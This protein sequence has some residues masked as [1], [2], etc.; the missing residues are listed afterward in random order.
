VHPAC[1]CEGFEGPGN[2]EIACDFQQRRVVAGRLDSPGGICPRGTPPVD[3]A[4]LDRATSARMVIGKF[5]LA[6]K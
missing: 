2:I 6:P 4:P 1:I 5:G 3:P